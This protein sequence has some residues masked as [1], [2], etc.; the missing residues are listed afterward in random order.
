V[1]VISVNISKE[2]GTIKQPVNEI[3]IIKNGIEGD[4]HTGVFNREIS[5]LSQGKIDQFSNEAGAR[6][7]K[8]GEFAENITFSGINQDAIGISDRFIIGDA[9]LE[10]TQ[11]GK[12]CHGSKCAIFNEI[13]KC[14]MPKEGIFCKVIKGGKIKPGDNIKYIKSK[15][16]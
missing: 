12:E 15:S 14:V 10:V 7:F 11:L 1:K 5:L 2:K 6:K 13:G 8:P 4:A 16:K 3:V 9:E